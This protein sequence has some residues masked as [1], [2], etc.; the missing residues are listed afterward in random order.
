MATYSKIKTY[1]GLNDTEEDRVEELAE[2]M[3]EDGWVE[4]YADEIE[5]W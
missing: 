4:K 5:E 2:S 1:C 3:I